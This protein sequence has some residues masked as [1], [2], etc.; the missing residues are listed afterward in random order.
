MDA[1]EIV[2]DLGAGIAETADQDDAKDDQPKAAGRLLHFLIEKGPG[3]EALGIECDC[4][5]FIHGIGD[6]GGGIRGVCQARLPTAA[7]TLHECTMNRR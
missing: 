2:G 1:R 3:C 5:A 7:N 4:Y 6:S